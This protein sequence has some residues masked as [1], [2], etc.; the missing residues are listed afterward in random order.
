MDIQKIEFN[1]KIYELPPV[2]TELATKAKHGLKKIQILNASP[3]SKLNL[4]YQQIDEYNKF[5][6]TFTVCSTGCSHCCK[7]NVVISSIE[8]AYIANNLNISYDSGNNITKDHSTSCTFLKDDTCSIYEYRPFNCRTF[9]TLDD[10]EYCKTTTEHIV[11]GSA[12]KGYGSDI[13]RMFKNE[14]EQLNKH[15][16][17]RDIRDFFPNK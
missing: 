8:A 6:K 13:Y 2:P 10:P 15:R 1:G 3:I 17:Y 14:L 12:E 16:A 9:H 7:I 4:I 11:Y 5:V